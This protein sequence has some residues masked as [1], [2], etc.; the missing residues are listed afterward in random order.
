MEKLSSGYDLKNPLDE[1]KEEQIPSSYLA[2]PIEDPNARKAINEVVFYP[3]S[4]RVQDTD[5]QTAANYGVFFNSDRAYEVISITHRHKTAGS[6]ASA[7]TLQ[8]E[9]LTS[10]T[11]K[12]AGTNLLATAFNLKASNNTTQFGVLT[13]TKTALII[14]RGDSLGMV[15]S[16]TLTDLAEVCVTVILKAI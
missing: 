10:G 13:N 16:G 8:I 5:A 7:V 9:K 14:R 4:G 2:N 15:T 6:H 1:I 3:V 11:A 12:G